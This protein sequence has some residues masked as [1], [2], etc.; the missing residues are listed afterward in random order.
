MYPFL[1]FWLSFSLNVEKL[2]SMTTTTYMTN[3]THVHELGAEI[4][5]AVKPAHLYNQIHFTK[6]PTLKEFREIIKFP[7]ISTFRVGYIKPLMLVPF[8]KLI[9]CSCSDMAEIQVC[10]ENIKGT[11]L[12]HCV[13]CYMYGIISLQNTHNLHPTALRRVYDMLYVWAMYDIM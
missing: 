4:V 2:F 1:A 5:F 10:W 12:I 9:T 8:L 3:S 6:Y 7:P 11:I 13:L